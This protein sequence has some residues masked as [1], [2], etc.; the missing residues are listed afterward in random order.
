AVAGTES[1]LRERLLDDPS[2]I[3]DGFEISGTERESEAGPIDVFGTDADDRPTVVELKRRRVG[4]DAVG[5]LGRYVS[6]I[7][8]EYPDGT[9]VRGIL[10]A[11]SV[12]ERAAGLLD[13]DG[14]EHVALDPPG[15]DGWDGEGVE[16]ADSD[17]DNGGSDEDGDDLID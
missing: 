15:D 2:L 3:A 5:Q 17:E 13:E 1:D 16:D 10:V 6:A 7:E 14:F 9:D 11:P 12:T 4:P 8:R